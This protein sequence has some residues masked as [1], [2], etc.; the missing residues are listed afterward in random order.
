ME[1]KNMELEEIN[2]DI[3]E[4]KENVFSE[5]AKEKIADLLTI[6]RD[7]NIILLCHPRHVFER[8]SEDFNTK[9]IEKVDWNSINIEQ[10]EK[11]NDYG[12][13][14]MVSQCLE[15]NQFRYL[16]N[17]ARH[18]I[19]KYKDLGIERFSF[20]IAIVEGVYD[21]SRDDYDYY[22]R[23]II[24]VTKNGFALGKNPNYTFGNHKESIWEKPLRMG[25]NY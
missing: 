24:C 17:K 13:F 6:R 23:G 18:M 22:A 21:F 16:K 15:N 8:V 19:K 14:S 20:P 12:K 1:Q 4:C 10:M 11:Y 3:V 5:E 7:G 25:D 2:Y 9:V